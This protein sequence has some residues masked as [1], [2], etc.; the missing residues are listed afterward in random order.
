MA[1][2]GIESVDVERLWII[3][4]SGHGVN[5]NL[6]APVGTTVA[7]SGILQLVNKFVVAMV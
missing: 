4:L 1:L 6:L 7:N 3:P 2:H 5:V